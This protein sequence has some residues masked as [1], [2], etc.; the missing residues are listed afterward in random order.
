MKYLALLLPCVLALCA[1]LYNRIDPQLF[2]MPFF[3]W[4]QLALIPISAL[5]L[6]AFDRLRRG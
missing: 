3:Y 4:A 2:G 1:P 5:G 6:F